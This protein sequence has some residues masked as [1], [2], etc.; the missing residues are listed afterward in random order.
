MID[1]H[2][3]NVR[4]HVSKELCFSI[5]GGDE[6]PKESPGISTADT[7]WRVQQVPGKY[8]TCKYNTGIHYKTQLH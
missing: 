4:K 6:Q 7:W 3:D 2:T 5:S 1:G 8:N